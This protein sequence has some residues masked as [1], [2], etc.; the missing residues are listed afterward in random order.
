MS[1]TDE[2]GIKEVDEK[3]VEDETSAGG[4]EGE[5]DDEV[6]VEME[7]EMCE[8]IKDPE[9]T[10]SDSE[11]DSE[12]ETFVSSA[13]DDAES[14]KYGAATETKVVKSP[15]RSVMENS[16]D[17]GT[18]DGEIQATKTQEPALTLEERI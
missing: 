3:R 6:E 1:D 8:D 16:T 11:P 15:P 18:N 12:F 5:G 14:N 10:S 13:G 7:L 9:T 4:A 2:I 17:G